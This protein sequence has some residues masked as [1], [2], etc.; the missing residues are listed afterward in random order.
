MPPENAILRVGDIYLQMAIIIRIELSFLALKSVALLFLYQCKF[1][2]KQRAMYQEK[3]WQYYNK[4]YWELRGMGTL[5][6]K[7]CRSLG[8]EPS[9]RLKLGPQHSCHKTLNLRWCHKFCSRFSPELI[10]APQIPNSWFR[11]SRSRKVSRP[12]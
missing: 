8:A 12:W 3:D 6:R 9:S 4:H 11:L 5:A 1:S 10:A 2:V 7:C